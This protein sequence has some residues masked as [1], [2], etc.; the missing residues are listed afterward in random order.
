MCKLLGFHLLDLIAAIPSTLGFDREIIRLKRM[1]TSGILEVVRKA[2]LPE[3]FLGSNRIEI[4]YFLFYVKLYQLN[5]L[6]GENN[7][8]E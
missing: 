7:I 2:Y 4:M 8:S 5:N 6:H 1:N 3:H